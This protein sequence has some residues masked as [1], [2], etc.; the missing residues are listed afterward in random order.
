MKKLVKSPNKKLSHLFW[1]EREWL[2]GRFK[3]KRGGFSEGAGSALRNPKRA[4]EGKVTVAIRRATVLGKK[5]KF[6][7]K[8]S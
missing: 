5:G 1:R 7:K 8:S 4:R 3:K 6:G 2:Q